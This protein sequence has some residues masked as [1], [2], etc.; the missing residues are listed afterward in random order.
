M[1]SEWALKINQ[2]TQNKKNCL[3][4]TTI[5]FNVSFLFYDAAEES[6]FTPYL[7]MTTATTTQQRA[8]WM[9]LVNELRGKLQAAMNHKTLMRVNIKKFFMLILHL[10]RLCARCNI[11]LWFFSSPFN[12]QLSKKK[13]TRL[14]VHCVTRVLFY[15]WRNAFVMAATRLKVKTFY[16]SSTSTIKENLESCSTHCLNFIYYYVVIVVL[17]T[18]FNRNHNQF[19][20]IPRKS[21]LIWPTFAF[22]S[23][24]Q[25]QSQAFIRE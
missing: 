25:T 18:N 10:S 8:I 21:L 23:S 17:A 3:L 6:N 9:K 12:A 14:R 22:Y 7:N 4:F 11:N 15:F 5:A 16:C 1:S 24:I 2:R 19:H 20:F 13:R